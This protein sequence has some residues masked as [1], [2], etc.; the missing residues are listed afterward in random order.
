[1]LIACGAACAFVVALQER[2]GVF[3]HTLRLSVGTED[4]G[5]LLRELGY[6]EG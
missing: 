6:L 4:A 3:E 1:M 2:A 5:D